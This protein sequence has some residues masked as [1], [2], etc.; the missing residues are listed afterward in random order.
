[1]L[2]DD[3]AVRIPLQNDPHDLSPASV[4]LPPSPLP[5]ISFP[6]MGP[7][8]LGGSGRPS[9]SPRSNSSSSPRLISDNH[10]G[11]S[12]FPPV[13]DEPKV[14]FEDFAT[15]YR[16]SQRKRTQRKHLEK[17]LRAAKVSIG[18]S[19]RIIRIGNTVQRGLVEAL[20]QDDKAN[21]VSLYHMLYDLQESCVS[22]ARL[23]E[24]DLDEHEPSDP[25]DRSDFFHQLS[26]QSRSDLLE[27]LRLVRSDPQFLVDRLRSFSSAQ[28]A[29]FTSPAT[30]LDSGDPA[31]PSSSRSRSQY[32]F[33]R[34][35]AQSAP[36]KDHA[37][38]FERTDPL[39]ILL[40]NVFAAPLEPETPEASLRIDVWSSVCAQLM[41]HGSSK[42]YPLI[43]QVL[44]SWATGSNWK[45]RPKFELYLMDIL[46]TG[47]FLLE[48]IDTPAGLD[49][50]AEALDPLRT[51]VAE[52]FFASA[53]DDLFRLLDDPDGG[54]PRA[55]LQFAKAVLQKLDHPDSRSRFL[56]YLFVQWF[57]PKFL[58]SALTYPEV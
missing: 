27:I 13:Q 9:P 26:P 22:S 19:S 48:H 10:L 47:A 40:C 14:S 3:P 16:Q 1:M 24:Q 41:S 43:G 5:A 45:A 52:E 37:Y 17:R 39:S 2:I 51:D 4:P 11:R 44:S 50:A 30:T 58:Y 33:N 8:E 57:F 35:P 32:S 21:F 46:Q 38:A 28:L 12:K 7:S 25:E 34:N 6:E 36:F 31:F 49:F 29:A 56:E 20:K 42:F 15:R 18:V 53:V 23:D 55:V 54:F